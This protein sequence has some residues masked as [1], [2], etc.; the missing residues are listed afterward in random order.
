MRLYIYRTLAGK[1]RATVEYRNRVIEA[2]GSSRKDAIHEAVLH[3][4]IEMLN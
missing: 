4:Y 2:Y 3:A 1:W